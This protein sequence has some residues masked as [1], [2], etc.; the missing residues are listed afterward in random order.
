MSTTT[1]DPQVAELR[2]GDV[3]EH[4]LLTGFVMVIEAV[5]PCETDT[6][7]PAPHNSFQIVDP[8]GNVDWLCGY[9]VRPVDVRPVDGRRGA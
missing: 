3:I 8:E 6:A 2:V 7:R 4:K 5:E 1:L 9:D